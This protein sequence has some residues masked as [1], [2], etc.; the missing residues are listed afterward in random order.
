MAKELKSKGRHDEQDARGYGGDDGHHHGGNHEALVPASCSANGKSSRDKEEDRGPDSSGKSKLFVDHA[1]DVG[2]EGDEAADDV[3]DAKGSGRLDVV[4][5]LDVHLVLRCLDDVDHLV[6]GVRCICSTL[7]I[8]FEVSLF[9]G[10]LCQI[11]C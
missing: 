11:C 4:H 3:D 5:I 10:T 8:H 7:L 1:S 9:A 2:G 6:W